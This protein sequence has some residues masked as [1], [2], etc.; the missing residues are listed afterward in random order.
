M[1]LT[2]HLFRKSDLNSFFYVWGL[3]CVKH[4]SMEWE[5][6]GVPFDLIC[7]GFR[8]CMHVCLHLLCFKYILTISVVHFVVLHAKWCFFFFHILGCHSQRAYSSQRTSN[9]ICQRQ[10]PSHLLGTQDPVQTGNGR[11]ASCRVWDI[12]HSQRLKYLRRVSLGFDFGRNFCFKQR[13]D[14]FETTQN[15]VGSL[16]SH[17][18]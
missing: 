4:F 6:E 5:S 11:G 12:D 7:I 9:F 3:L 8:T 10:K 1:Q 15:C 18:L 14:H 13:I 2:W 17:K 16:M